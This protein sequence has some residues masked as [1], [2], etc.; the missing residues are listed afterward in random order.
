MTERKIKKILYSE[1]ELRATAQRIGKQI[2]ED[3]A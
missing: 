3:Y 1:E 2:S